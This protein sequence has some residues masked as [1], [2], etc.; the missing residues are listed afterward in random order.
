MRSVTEQEE[1]WQGSFGD[2]YTDRNTS[3]HSSNV[4]LFSRVLGKT[5]GVSR[6]FEIGVNRGLNLDALYAVAPNVKLSGIEINARAAAL[7]K[8]KHSGVI[9]GSILSTRIEGQ[10]DL[11]FTK[12]VLIHIAPDKLPDVYV[13]MSELSRRYVLI[14]E[15]Y[16][17][18]PVA[19]NYRGHSGKLFKRDFAGEFMDASGFALVDYGFFYRRDPVYPADDINWFLMERRS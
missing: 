3:G 7:A 1:F 15:Y 6:I 2:E 19:I 4:A 8:T 17:P 9:E 18:Q 10:Y 11:V 13:R 12:G 16:S 14:A 5:R